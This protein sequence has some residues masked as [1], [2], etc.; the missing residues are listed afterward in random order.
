MRRLV[1]QPE[2][3]LSA[4]DLATV[5]AADPRPAPEHRPW[6]AVNMVSSIDGSIQLDGRS[7][8]LGGPSDRA[9]F[10][11]L[12]EMPDVILAGAGTVRTE[13]Y[14][15]VVLGEEG[16]ARRRSR[17]QAG[18]P[19]LAV[20]SAALHLDPAARLFGDPTQRPIVVTCAAAPD[21]ARRRLATVADV[22]VAGDD[23][24]DLADAMRQLRDVGAEVVL[25]EG[26]P[27]LNAALLEA[28]LVDEWDQTIA[29]LLVTGSPTRGSAGALPGAVRSLTLR[30]LLVDDE[31]MLLARY[32]R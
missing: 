29:P 18:V 16:R 4:D 9:M 14:G 23:T 5:V 13:D 8:G 30:R 2:L 21:E 19:R 25:C 7:G 1:P 32:S 15:P 6:L 27:T 22:L 3:E 24:V 11:A 28:D 17:G 26:G 31:G 12:R 20:V 10:R